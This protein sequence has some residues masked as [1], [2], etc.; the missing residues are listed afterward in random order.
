M[1]FKEVNEAFSVLG[2][3]DKRRQYDK[4]GT[5]GAAG[6]IFGSGYTRAT[7]EDLTK[8]FVGAGPGFDFLDNIFGDALSGVPAF[9]SRPL[10]TALV[11][12]EV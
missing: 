7:F 8:D 12:A 3:P 1:K 6:D 5:G 2:D 11:A 4:F 9:L 10:G